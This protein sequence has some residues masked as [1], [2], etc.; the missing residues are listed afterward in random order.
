MSNS[1]STSPGDRAA[2]DTPPHGHSPADQDVP[3]AA[4]LPPAPGATTPHNT[5]PPPAQPRPQPPPRRTTPTRT[6]PATTPTRPAPPRLHGI[7]LA[8]GLAVLGMFVIHVGIGWTLADGTNPLTDLV[9]GRAAALFALLAGVSIALI[10]GG[11]TPATGHTM[12]IALWRV[13]IRGL[14]MLPLGVALTMLDTPIA[15]IL[16]YYA[17]YFVLAVPLIDERWRIVAGCAAALALAGPLASFW[18]RRMIDQGPLRDAAA[19]VNT[20]DPLVALSGSGVIDLLLTGSYPALT[21][22]PYVLAGLAIGRLDLRSTR[23]RA[24]LTATG[25]ALAALAYTASWAAM[26]LMGG[27]QRLDATYNAAAMADHGGHPDTASAFATG[28][29]GTIPTH[30]WVWLLTALP[31]SGTPLEIL[32]AG[33]TAIAVLGL[34]LL[35][36]DLLRIVCYP[37]A[38]VGALALTVYVAHVLLLWA[39][40]TALLDATPLAFLT[41]DLA[42]TVLWGSLILATLWR[43]LLGRGPLERPLHAISTWAATRIP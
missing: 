26:D 28:F 2:D 22:L 14:A 41:A 10:S 9:S 43:L 30:D 25:T 34:C 40:E 3:T 7:D 39:A 12:G 5:A 16:A 6:P 17:V 37:I 21:W 8:R 1:T 11:S 4:P 19:A 20:Y 38:A 29:T 23:V 31:H 36:G 32:G 15:V 18:L 13:L 35:L 33:G 24:A 42:A 27:R